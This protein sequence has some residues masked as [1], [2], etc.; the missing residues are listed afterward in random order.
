MGCPLHFSFLIIV[1]SGPLFVPCSP[2]SLPSPLDFCGRCLLR[3]SF[4]IIDYLLYDAYRPI[5]CPLFISFSISYMQ[6]L[7]SLLRTYDFTQLQLCLLF[8]AF[9]ST[10][11]DGF[12]L[13]AIIIT[14]SFSCLRPGVIYFWY[15]I[16]SAWWSFAQQDATAFRFFW[17]QDDS[18]GEFAV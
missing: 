9:K 10:D 15:F 3:V 2:S 14:P 1:H 11:T 16:C 13:E 5:V 12:M 6:L 17:P 8:M 7:F 4:H 18:A